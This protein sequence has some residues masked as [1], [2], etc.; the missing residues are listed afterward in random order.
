[1]VNIFRSHLRLVIFF[2]YFHGQPFKLLGGN[3][4]RFL[5]FLS[6]IFIR[7]GMSDNAERRRDYEVAGRAGRAWHS[8]HARVSLN[9][10]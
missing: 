2:G 5:R 3:V 4:L 7:M 8:M 6:K 10:L 1:M 9:Y